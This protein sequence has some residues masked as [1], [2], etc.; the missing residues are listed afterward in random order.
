MY[1]KI[2]NPQN[3]SGIKI[4]NYS[5]KLDSEEKIIDVKIIDKNKILAF[6]TNKDQLFFLV[7]DL[8]KNKVVSRIGR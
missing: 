7:Y 5:L 1:S 6:V 4:S 2:S 8:K 3:V